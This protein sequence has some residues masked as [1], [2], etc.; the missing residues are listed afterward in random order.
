MNLIIG[1]TK[2]LGRALVDSFLAKGEEVVLFNRGKLAADDMP[3][4]EIVHGDRNTELAELGG[5]KWKSVIDTCGYLPQTVKTSVEFFAD[6]VEQ[7]V[8]ISSISAYGDFSK[9]DFDEATP[10][11]TL[12]DEQQARADAIDPLQDITAPILEDLYGALKAQCEQ[13][14]EAAMPGRVLVIR[15]GLIVGPYDWTDRFTYWVKRIAEGGEV[16]A[17]GDPDRFVQFIDVRDLADW[18]AKMAAKGATGVYN[19]DGKTFDITMGG[20]LDEIRSTV[21]SDTTFTW[22]PEEFILGE[23]VQPWNE[24]PL[25]LPE[26][27]P[28]SKGF[29]SANIDK[30]ISAKLTFRPF[31][32][33]VKDT[34]AWRQATTAEIPFKAGITREREVELL[35]KFKQQ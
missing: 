34:L 6:K 23:S 11:A 22:V 15:P 2:F 35:R 10:L 16:L 4:V 29:L 20:M 9:P 5:R 21:G 7:Y 30:A 19:A 26:S 13:V 31:A 25:Y 24:M 17:P 1:G 27:D 14:A 12:N 8:F 18:T 33:T 3:D 32:E 28:E